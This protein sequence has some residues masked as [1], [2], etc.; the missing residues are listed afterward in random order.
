[1]GLQ[2]ERGSSTSGLIPETIHEVEHS[3]FDGILLKSASNRS[4]RRWYETMET[5]VNA[6]ARAAAEALD[7]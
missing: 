3:F 4:L 2:A 7:R 6:A 1:L 5:Y